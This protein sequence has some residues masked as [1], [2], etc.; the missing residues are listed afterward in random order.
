MQQQQQQHV[1]ARE[2]DGKGEATDEPEVE[3]EA[4]EAEEAGESEEH[5]GCVGDGD[6]CDATTIGASAVASGNVSESERIKDKNRSAVGNDTPSSRTYWKKK[7]Q[8]RSSDVGNVGPASRG[9][10]AGDHVSLSSACSLA[11]APT[12]TTTTAAAA[13]TVA[14]A[15]SGCPTI[16]NNSSTNSLTR[17]GLSFGG[18]CGSGGGGGGGGC[19]SGLATAMKKRKKKAVASSSELDSLASGTSDTSEDESVEPRPVCEEKAKPAR[20]P[21]Q[22]GVHDGA[23]ASAA[24][25]VALGCK[26]T[27]QTRSGQQLR[28][29]MRKVVAG[30]D[31]AQRRPVRKRLGT[32]E[33]TGPMLLWRRR[34]KSRFQI[35]PSDDARDAHRKDD[36]GGT[37]ETVDVPPS[38]SSTPK[39]RATRS[40][41]AAMPKRLVS[42]A[43]TTTTTTTTATT[44]ASPSPTSVTSTA[45]AVPP[46]TGS[47]TATT[48]T[49]S[50]LMSFEQHRPG[51]S[52]SKQSLNQLIQAN[53]V[54]FCNVLDLNQLHENLYTRHTQ[55][56][57]AK[58]D[59]AR[60]RI[61]SKVLHRDRF[62]LQQVI[63]LVEKI[64]KLMYYYFSWEFHEMRQVLMGKKS[65]GATATVT[66]SSSVAADGEQPHASRFT[67]KD[68]EAARQ[69]V[70]EEVRGSLPLTR[71]PRFDRKI[72]EYFDSLVRTLKD[73]PSRSTQTFYAK[74][75][76][77][78]DS[79]KL[80]NIFASR[81]ILA[82]VKNYIRS[83]LLRVLRCRLDDDATSSDTLM[84]AGDKRHSDEPAGVR[85]AATAAAASHTT[86]GGSS[87]REKTYCH[88]NSW[89]KEYEKFYYTH[90]FLQIINYKFLLYHRHC[91]VILAQLAAQPN[92]ASSEE[93]GLKLLP[94][95][96]Y[97][98]TDDA[99]FPY[100]FFSVLREQRLF[101]N[102][103]ASSNAPCSAP[104]T[105]ASLPGN[106]E[107]PC[108]GADGVAGA[109]PGVDLDTVTS[110]QA[111]DGEVSDAEPDAIEVIVPDAENGHGNDEPDTTRKSTAVV[112]TASLS[113]SASPPDVQDTEMIVLDDHGT[114][115]ASPPDDKS[116]VLAT[117][118]KSHDSGK[119][120]LRFYYH[121]LALA[122]TFST[123]STSGLPNRSTE[124][125]LGDSCLPSAATSTD[126]S[127]TRTITLDDDS[128]DVVVLSSTEPEPQPQPPSTTTSIESLLHRQLQMVKLLTEEPD[129][130]GCATTATAVVSTK[131]VNGG[132]RLNAQYSLLERTVLRQYFFEL[133]IDEQQR[134]LNSV[135]DERY[136]YVQLSPH[137]RTH[138]RAV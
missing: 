41:Q 91:E 29:V 1:A 108:V 87:A 94:P 36:E 50:V 60:T 124:A 105:P 15:T 132:V 65:S 137:T 84:V 83:Y 62:R 46:T 100:W 120:R 80:S 13:T 31:T 118:N 57:S 9:E 52:Q 88:I 107:Q 133:A 32:N 28:S 74:E 129:S 21:T 12:L 112:S 22:I 5:H 126:S 25:A 136:L 66:G 101:N 96:Y 37:A 53:I 68:V 43:A 61:M 18:G 44:L 92:T 79:M 122:L 106:D 40:R 73:E 103:D 63:A 24:V 38:A 17:S 104:P 111:S 99:K 95:H 69:V 39:P 86:A 119:Y 49:T 123:C 82:P 10:S 109:P 48:P 121:A 97:R 3:A 76:A 64:S 85:R 81:S 72:S 128:A 138:T 56:L 47:S 11:A 45:Q 51:L 30:R 102:L 93:S 27:P 23:L 115:P 54:E 8:N 113:P 127:T 7:I 59:A 131:A 33:A 125:V 77:I 98:A 135:A 70:C 35:Q 4:A 89:R 67:S 58:A 20:A 117:A 14:A 90:H 71:N 55:F 114:A 6:N 42:A 110:P 78:Y 75:R 134:V 2:V 34:P 16:T 130:T 19:G 116:L 26:T